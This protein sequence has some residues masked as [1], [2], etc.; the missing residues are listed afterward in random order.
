MDRCAEIPQ[1]VANE[2]LGRYDGANAIER[3]FE[4]FQAGKLENGRTGIMVHYVI[5]KVDRGEPILVREIECREGDSLHQLEERIHAHEHELIV[6]AT[7]KVAQ[8]I[9][10]RKSRTQ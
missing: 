8:E 9:V 1:A 6:E 7:A 4:D 10:A 5:N 2:P 3:A